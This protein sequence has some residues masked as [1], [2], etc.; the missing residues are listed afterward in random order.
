VQLPALIDP[1]ANVIAHRLQNFTDEKRMTE[2][3]KILLRQI[4]DSLYACEGNVFI[5]I[6]EVQKVSFHSSYAHL[7]F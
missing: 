3:Q 5:M 4:A 6:D 7:E 1:A 2:Y